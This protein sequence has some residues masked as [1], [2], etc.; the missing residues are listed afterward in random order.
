M[1]FPG[2][3]HAEYVISFDLAKAGRWRFKKL[4]EIAESDEG[5]LALRDAV[6]QWKEMYPD[7]RAK[8]DAFL[9][10]GKVA[11]AVQKALAAERRR[12]EAREK[13]CVKQPRGGTHAERERAAEYGL[14]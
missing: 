13:R 3:P 5:L 6:L 9:R 11:D 2:A 10:N 14:F 7:T 4:A 12:L 8:I 1:A